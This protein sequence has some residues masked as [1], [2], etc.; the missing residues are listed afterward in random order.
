MLFSFIKYTNA[1]SYFINYQIVLV[2]IEGKFTPSLNI[3]F[4]TGSFFSFVAPKGL[5][6]NM[7]KSYMDL[8]P[9]RMAISN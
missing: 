8:T 7:Y 5:K 2:F 9:E 4:A 6:S 1:V 3:S